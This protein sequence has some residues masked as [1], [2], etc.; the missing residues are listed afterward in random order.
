M[1]YYFLEK[2]AWPGSRDPL[3]FWPLNADRSKKR[4]KLQTSNFTRVFPRTRRT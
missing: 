3:N 2:G 1:T 4:L